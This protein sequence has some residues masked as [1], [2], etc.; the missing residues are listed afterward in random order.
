MRHVVVAGAA[1]ARLL[2]G[3]ATAVAQVNYVPG[4]FV[5]TSKGPVEL[6]VYAE[7]LPS[8]RMKLADGM[9]L[10][11]VP[12]VDTVQRFLCSLPNWKPG[13]VWIASDA[14]FKDEYSERRQVTAGYRML[15]V[16]TTEVRVA[17]LED[18]GKVARL[19]KQVRPNG[20]EPAFAFI[21][22]NASGIGRHYLVRLR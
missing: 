3:A 19:V 6:I 12:T 20:S 18:S 11:D 13:A 2:L 5:G 8:G 15:N 16:Y 21:S 10:E 17:D 9:S 4:V 14:I 1:V 7:V 22:L